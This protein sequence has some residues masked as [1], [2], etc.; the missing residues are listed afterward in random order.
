MRAGSVE[1]CWQQGGSV[2]ILS[3]TVSVLVLVSRVLYW[4]CRCILLGNYF[5]QH[6][7]HWHE[8]MC[9]PIHC[10]HR[11]LPPDR[12]LCYAAIKL[13]KFIQVCG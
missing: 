4:S 2:F 6:V 10:L 13:D 12:K 7:C 11:L 1:H 8:P 3:V 9:H 5:L